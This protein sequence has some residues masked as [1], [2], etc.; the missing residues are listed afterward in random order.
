MN[1]PQDY[2]A[3]ILQGGGTAAALIRNKA[4]IS[5]SFVERVREMLDSGAEQSRPMTLDTVPEFLTDIAIALS[6]RAE[7]LQTN[8]AVQHGVVRAKL[9]NYSL[10]SLVKEYQL[11][12]EIISETLGA[13][14][15]PPTPT[16]WRIVHRCI[17]RAIAD[18]AA[19]FV[20]AHEVIREQF[21]ATLTHD[22]RGPLGAIQNYLDLIRVA[23][24]DAEQRKCF[25]ARATQN[26]ER[27][28]R[29]V[30][31]VL[32]ASRAGAGERIA[33]RAKPCDLVAETREL[34]DEF[35]LREGGRFVFESPPEL[36]GYCDSERLRQALENLLSNAIKYGS[37]E[38][39]ITVR[40][41]SVGSRVHMSVHNFG[42]PL[43]SEA[44][45]QLFRAYK[46]GMTA[47]K[48]GH[49]GW[50]LGLVLVE[51]IAE[52]HGGTV[53]LESSEDHGTT[54]T[55]DILQDVRDLDCSASDPKAP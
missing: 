48:S 26:V 17:D 29:M 33:V 34:V 16:E 6:Q 40:I 24:D 27:I 46:R 55:L 43:P 1:S 19:A 5:S 25:V 20:Q 23:G 44:R 2:D 3:R 32:D 7:D 18:A 9:S 39:P 52:A 49:R 22:L 36:H 21:T 37:T 30:E 13:L 15:T 8:I 38:G 10:T 45:E 31:D 28:G 42:D 47:E 14:S 53:L 41:V 35:T 50:G 12:R 54:F 11:L 4:A 51:A